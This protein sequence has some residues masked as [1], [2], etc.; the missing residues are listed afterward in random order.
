MMCF[1]GVGVSYQPIPAELTANINLRQTP[2]KKGKIIILLKKGDR[3]F[4]NEETPKWAK[5]VYDKSGQQING[6]V[7]TQYLK[8]TTGSSQEL[9]A[10]DVENKPAGPL[11]QPV[12]DT[13]PIN[14]SQQSGP[15]LAQGSEKQ[16]IVSE[17]LEPSNKSL[18]RKQRPLSGDDVSSFFRSKESGTAII[19]DSTLKPGAI[20]AL[21][22]EFIGIIMRMLFKISIVVTSCVAL[23]FSYSALRIA[24]SNNGGQYHQ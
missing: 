1:P 19:E 16:A 6:W 22:F 7:S 3:I 8:K 2:H 15:E 10:K 12:S 5:I 23:I 11:P 21:S 14:P 13:T 18:Q 24:K 4:I 20:P 17:S 9:K